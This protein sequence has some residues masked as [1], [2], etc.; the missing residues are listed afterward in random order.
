[1]SQAFMSYAVMNRT[2]L[3][4]PVMNDLICPLP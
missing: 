1:M 3:Y 2:V 4:E